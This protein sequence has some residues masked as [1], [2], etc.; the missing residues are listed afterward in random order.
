M[1]SSSFNDAIDELFEIGFGVEG[2]VPDLELGVHSY[3]TPALEGGEWCQK[4]VLIAYF[5]YKKYA[6]IGGE[7]VKIPP[8][9]AYVVYDWYLKCAV[10]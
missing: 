5:Q 10:V 3:I 9:C 7:G 4:I 2:A 8:N 1:S 6:Y